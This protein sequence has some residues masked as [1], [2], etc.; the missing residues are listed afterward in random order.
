MARAIEMEIDS[1]PM[2]EMWPSVANSVRWL[3]SSKIVKRSVREIFSIY[4]PFSTL[5]NTGG[6]L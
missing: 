3:G 2:R 1:L 5:T 6:L 4:S